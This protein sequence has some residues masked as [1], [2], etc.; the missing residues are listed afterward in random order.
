MNLKAFTLVEMLAGLAIAALVVTLGFY[1]I[2]LLQKQYL[3]FEETTNEALDYRRVEALLWHD[4]TNAQRV[5]LENDS[6]IR[7]DQGPILVEYG[8]SSNYL[9][10]SVLAETA[11]IDTF[12]IHFALQDATFGGKRISAGLMD[13]CVFNIG[14]FGVNHSFAVRKL[15]SVEERINHQNKYEH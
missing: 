12:P 9:T 15:Y 1:G 3:L 2:Q 11:I 6:S 8:I 13:H 14:P 4:F 10:R 7:C 5:L